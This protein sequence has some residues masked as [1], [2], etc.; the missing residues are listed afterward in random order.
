M[1]FLHAFFTRFPFFQGYYFF[2]LFVPKVIKGLLTFPGINFTVHMYRIWQNA[3]I[4]TRVAVTAARC[5]TSRA[6]ST[7]IFATKRR[8]GAVM[9]MRRGPQ[10]PMLTLPPTGATGEAAVRP[11]RH[12]WQ[13]LH[14]PMFQGYGRSLLM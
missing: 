4:Q 6:W 7:A 13:P 12:Q 3:G 1:S 11:D 9:R 14:P 5:A 10:P 2:V 8:L